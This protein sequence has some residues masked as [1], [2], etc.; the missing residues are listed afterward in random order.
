MYN[1]MKN[2]INK[3]KEALKIKEGLK[4]LLYNRDA[5][6]CNKNKL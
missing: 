6:S 3:M 5:V 4:L 1:R 2:E